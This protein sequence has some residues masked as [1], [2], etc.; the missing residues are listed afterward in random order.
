MSP[1]EMVLAAA[2]NGQAEAI[3]TYN[4]ED[5]RPVLTLGVAIAVPGEI[6]RRL[7]T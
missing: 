7:N 6:V 3:V 1:M 4:V 2:L 5:F